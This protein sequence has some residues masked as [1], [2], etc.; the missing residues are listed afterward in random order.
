MK[1]SKIIDK[2][3]QIIIIILAIVAVIGLVNDII[4][5]IK[6]I[7]QDNCVEINGKYYCE[8]KVK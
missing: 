1:I 7:K 5:Q 2:V 3:T 6:V 8:V 4:V